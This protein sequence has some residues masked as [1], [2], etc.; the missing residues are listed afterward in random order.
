M[1]F[2]LVNH[3][4]GRQEGPFLNDS[5]QEPHDSCFHCRHRAVLRLH[6]RRGAIDRR[7]RARSSNSVGLRF[8][9]DELSHATGRQ[10]CLC[11]LPNARSQHPWSHSKMLFTSG[12][13]A[14]GNIAIIWP[15]FVTRFCLFH[16]AMFAAFVPTA[17]TAAV[18]ENL[19]VRWP[20][21]CHNF[22]VFCR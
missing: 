17:C 2:H 21:V 10:R 8:R 19:R 9:I 4:Q 14:T 12:G 13:T 20:I 1:R 15:R 7:R 6:Q 5:N 16:C 22:C 18:V 11:S 3:S